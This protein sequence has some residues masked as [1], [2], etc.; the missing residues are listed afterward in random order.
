MRNRDLVDV[1]LTRFRSV[2]STAGLCSNGSRCFGTVLASLSEVSVVMKYHDVL[3]TQ[4]SIENQNSFT[5]PRNSNEFKSKE[6]LHQNKFP[7]VN[8][9]SSITLYATPIEITD[10]FLQARHQPKSPTALI[11]SSTSAQI[12]AILTTAQQL[13][14]Q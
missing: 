1:M 11:F 4:P 10:P 9:T 2:L 13:H 3:N 5:I 6:T 8:S 14:K 12:V 7:L